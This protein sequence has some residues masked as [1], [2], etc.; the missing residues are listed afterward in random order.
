MQ[1]SARPVQPEL[2][3]AR[4]FRAHD[5]RWVRFARQSVADGAV[6]PMGHEL[7]YRWDHDTLRQDEPPSPF[8]VSMT[9][10]HALLDGGLRHRS[11][12]CL[13]V[14][15]DAP[16]LLSTV[17][18]ALCAPLF[19]I[20]LPP[21]LAVE[22]ATTRRI[23]QLHARGYR[24]A[25]A[26]LGGADDARWGWAPFA[27]YAK[28]PVSQLPSSSWAGWLARAHWADLK[29]IADGLREPTDYLGLRRLGV[30]FFQGDLIHSPQEESVR[31]LPCCDGQV[32]QKL[33]R[34]V[35]R[36]AARDT[37]AMVGA[38]DPALVIRLLMLQRMYGGGPAP[39]AVLTD[40]LEALPYRVL[41]GWLR[42]LRG[43]SL[44]PHERGRAWSSSVRE[45]M[46]NFRAR[47]IGARACRTPMELEARVF[48]LYRRLCS[49]ESLV[50]LLPPEDEP[51]AAAQVL[52]GD[53]V[54]APTS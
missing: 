42:I 28:L 1:P 4:R 10:S 34:L 35:E 25:L 37:L 45:Q 19:V 26:D 50:A 27:T 36:G 24:F 49:R 54:P 16:A 8:G 15:L 32:L 33:N 17:A 47:L 48:D 22:A 53:P 43:S 29:V 6:E 40:V 3:P 52:S 12:G 23:A 30:Q 31:A 9:L 2:P 5:I 20:Q 51:L 13:F 21:S 18:D 7:S 14:T 38:T 46:Y 39:A 11:S 41:A 44:D